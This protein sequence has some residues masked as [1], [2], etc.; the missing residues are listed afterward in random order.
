MNRERNH[1]IVSFALVVC[2]RTMLALPARRPSAGAVPGRWGAC[3]AVRTP[4]AASG[5]VFFQALS[6]QVFHAASSLPAREAKS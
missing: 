1:M 3:L 2:D 5:C 4:P 6:H